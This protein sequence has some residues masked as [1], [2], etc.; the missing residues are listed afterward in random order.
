MSKSK[1][2]K[3]QVRI[4]KISPRLLTVVGGTITL[5]ALFL[6]TDPMYLF[7]EKPV[8]PPLDAPYRSRS[9]T[10]ELRAQNLISYMTLREKIGQMALI[11]K[12]S[13]IKPSDV[14]TYGL[15]ALL[16]GAGAKPENNTFEGW[17][18]MV[19]N[20][21]TT[22]KES[23]LGIPILYGIDSVHG[24]SNVP[25]ATV[26]PHAIGLG[27]SGN[28]DLV[29]EVARVTRE[30]MLATGIIWNFSPT[31]DLP[32][33][34]RWGRTYE[35]FSDDPILTA[36][37]GAAYVSGFEGAA[38]KKLGLSTLKHYIGV[39]SMNWNT[40]S[41]KNFLID[42]GTIT[43]DETKLKDTYLLPFKAGIDTG[44]S[45]VMVG[46]SSWGET[47]LAAEKYLV[48]DVLKNELGFSG[49]T[50]S[51]WYGIYEIQGGEYAATVTAINAGIDMVML[52]FDYKTFI[53]NVEK[54]VKRGDIS[55]ER[56]DDAVTRILTTKFELGLF[57]TTQKNTT[58]LGNDANR[59]VARQA[60]AESLVL[61]KDD[62]NILPLSQ[63]SKTIRV[64]G[65]AADNIGRQ[66]G[67]WTV[68]WQG[69]DGN[70][71]PGATSILKDDTSIEYSQTGI[72]DESGPNA[73]V[74]IAVVGEAP[75]AEGWGDNPNPTLSTEDL[76]AIENLRKNSDKLI[77][78]IVSGR[79]LIITEEIKTWDA[80]IAA[81]LPGS[82]GAG[83][84]DVLFGDKPFTGS[85]PLPWPA[86]ISQVPIQT[87]GTTTDGT[88][89]L[90]PR[91]H[92]LR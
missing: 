9:T 11:E 75:Y 70:W 5:L 86:N 60:V 28:A 84:A 54:A 81:W 49:F 43:A 21:I 77:V 16:S 6:Y 2:A 68:E 20:F 30:E 18:S 38:D 55:Q 48:T 51:D 61:L 1:Q 59:A 12:N 71:L 78:I 82:E 4:R 53:K 72:F 37:L 33:D 79:P 22:S 7:S 66:S 63:T 27:A 29:E 8:T 57:D 35:T 91:Y 36:K 64:A 46:L 3:E 40:S 26:F 90:F 56:I 88:E 31:L 14:S 76:E 89:V 41:N 45:S 34:I 87:D 69:I 39:G 52:P 25:G 24:H 44:A 19:Q 13:I 83:V 42:Q 74:G 92:G 58:T 47:K 17:Q 73:A 10:P 32:T 67:A 50:V 65:S 62:S 85:L 80:A 15:G 23:R